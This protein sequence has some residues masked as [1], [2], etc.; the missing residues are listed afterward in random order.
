MMRDFIKNDSNEKDM[1]Q[2]ILAIRDYIKELEE[3]IK[4]IREN[5]MKFFKKKFEGL[6]LK[7]PSECVRYDLMFAALFGNYVVV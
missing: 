7:G 3:E 1:F 5:H 2:T 6:K 4:C